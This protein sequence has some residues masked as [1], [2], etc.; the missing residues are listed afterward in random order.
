MRRYGQ[1][2][3]LSSKLGSVRTRRSA[4]ILTLALVLN[5][6]LA[7][8]FLR[9]RCSL[10][11]VQRNLEVPLTM[12]AGANGWQGAE[13]LRDSRAGT[14]FMGWSFLLEL[15]LLDALHQLLSLAV[16][17]ALRGVRAGLHER[18]LPHARLRCKACQPS[19]LACGRWRIDWQR[20]NGSRL[21]SLDRAAFTKSAAVL[22]NYTHFFPT[23]TSVFDR[24]AE[25]RVFILLVV[26]SKGVLVEQ[27][28]FRVI[29][30]GFREVGKL[31]PDGSDQAG[32]SSHAF[33]VGHR[34]MGIADSE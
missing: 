5:K 27:D 4:D 18:S 16:F 14:L 33:V 20:T 32:L 1:F 17:E 15:L 29:R 31:L 2:R 30:T 10:E 28:Q 7:K 26:G 9:V 19:E 21:R 34:S 24:H 11:R 25:E 12:R 23:E 6:L 3:T 8:A 13:L 22:P